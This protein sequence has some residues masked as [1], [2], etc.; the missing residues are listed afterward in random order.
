MT[1]P[2]MRQ[3]AAVI[4]EWQ[5]A[6]GAAKEVRIVKYASSSYLVTIKGEFVEG[7]GHVGGYTPTGSYYIS[8]N[9]EI[10]SQT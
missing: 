5:R 6:N 10:T 2:Q 7:D 9:G 1:M 8:A 4:H 3:L